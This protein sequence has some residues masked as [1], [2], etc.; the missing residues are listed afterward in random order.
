MTSLTGVERIELADGVLSYGP[1]TAEAFVAR[2][3]L[4]LLGREGDV[5]GLSFAAE[6]LESGASR[7]DLV[8]V[9]LSGAE[10]KALRGAAQTDAAFV[11]GLYDAFLGRAGGAEERGSWTAAMDQ[12]ASR[13]EVAAAIAG[14]AEAGARMEAATDGVFVADFEGASARGLYKCALAR[15]GEAAGVKFW[16][17]AL[18]Q[19]TD[20]KALGDA[21]DDT[22]EFLARHGALTNRQYVEKLYQDGLGRTADAEGLDYWTGL[23]D[24]GRLGRGELA[25][26]YATSQ[27]VRDGLDWPL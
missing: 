8:N 20:L 15:E 11:E 19:G 25:V 13:A 17:D 21:F 5:G 12:G 4:G 9:F 16:S 6:A 18:E 26:G 14:S 1:G 10:Y 23:L 22:P 2:L 27:E 24:S 7:G 3:Y